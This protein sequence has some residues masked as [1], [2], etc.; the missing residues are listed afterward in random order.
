MKKAL[1]LLLTLILLT[2]SKEDTTEQTQNTTLEGGIIYTAQ[3]IEVNVDS[4]TLETYQGTLGDTPVELRK[5]TENSLVFFVEPD[6]EIGEKTLTIEGFNNFKVNYNVQKT[7]LTQTVA[8]TIQPYFDQIAAEKLALTPED[9]GDK[10]IQLIDG[11]NSLYASITDQQKEDISIFYKANKN[12]IDATITGDVNKFNSNVVTQFSRCKAS[13]YLT[14]ILGVFTTISTTLPFTQ[15]ATPILAVSTGIL[16]AKTYEH[17]SSLATETIKNVFVQADDQIFNSK[18]SNASGINLSSDVVSNVPFQL[19]NRTMLPSD[20]GDDNTIINTYF[21]ATSSFNELV[22]QKMNSAINYLNTEWSLFFNITPYNEV[23]VNETA[24][25]DT[26][27]LTQEDFDNFSFSVSGLNINLESLTFANGG[28]NLNVKI[29]DESI[30]T[31]G[32][33]TGTLNFTYQD[34]FNSFSGSFDIN[35]YTDSIVGTWYIN[36]PDCMPIGDCGTDIPITFNSNGTISS[37]LTSSS[38][39]TVNTNNYSYSNDT[40]TINLQYDEEINSDCNGESYTANTSVTN[41]LTFNRLSVNEFEGNDN[42][43]STGWTY[44]N[45]SGDDCDTLAYSFSENVTLSK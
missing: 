40:I 13:I 20:N 39:I 6:F 7:V 26:N 37:A 16:L 1:T 35:V 14:G 45:S 2:C 44:T 41:T 8:E 24:T 31:N 17:C 5:T 29:I 33:E 25:T 9:N 4:A 27:N 36:Y 30:V 18:M 42:Y 15:I 38:D 32:I 3:I 21:S 34:D 19:Q 43:S 12:L 22:V 10:A 23:L 28:L 11:F